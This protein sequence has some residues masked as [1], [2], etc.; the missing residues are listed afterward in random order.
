M[1][2]RGLGESDMSYTELMQFQLLVCDYDDGDDEVRGRRR[3][4]VNQL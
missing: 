2:L 1:W 4:M 3:I